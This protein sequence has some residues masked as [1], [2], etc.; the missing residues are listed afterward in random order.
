MPDEIPDDYDIPIGKPFPNERILLID[1]NENLIAENDTESKGEICVSG[2]CVSLGYIN[3]S[4]T[5]EV[6][7][8]NPLNKKYFERI[9]KTGD[10]GRYG[11]DGNLYYLGRKDN[12]IKHMGHRIELSE[13]DKKE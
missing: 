2:T 4:K 6:F 3:N 5:N 12:Q 13:I 8:Q 10:L 1:E 7:I 9:Y 11:K